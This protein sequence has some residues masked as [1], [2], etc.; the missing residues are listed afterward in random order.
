MRKVELEI[1]IDEKGKFGN[2]TTTIGCQVIEGYYEQDGCDM[3]LKNFSI[4]GKH[5]PGYMLKSKIYNYLHDL[6]SEE[7]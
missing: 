3:D 7:V 5:L 6:V 2:F 1:N 4:N